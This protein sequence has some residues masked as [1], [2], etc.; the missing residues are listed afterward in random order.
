MDIRMYPT[1]PL[2]LWWDTEA[3]VYAVRCTV[4]ERVSLPSYPGRSTVIFSSDPSAPSNRETAS[5]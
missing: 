4:K 1:L 2:I 5:T 3:A